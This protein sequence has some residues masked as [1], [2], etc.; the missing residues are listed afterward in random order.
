M[1]ESIFTGKSKVIGT[2]GG[3]SKQGVT[4]LPGLTVNPKPTRAL[5]AE[6]TNLALK[7][8]NA[9]KPKA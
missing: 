4:P 3:E 1:S 6:Q 5:T 8:K 2:N 9:Q 7:I